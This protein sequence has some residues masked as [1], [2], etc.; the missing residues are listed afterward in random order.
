MKLKII[1]LTTMCFLV[2]CS[3]S[4]RYASEMRTV[5]Y[6]GCEYTY[7]P[8]SGSASL[9]HKGNCKG[10]RIREVSDINNLK[11][12]IDYQFQSHKIE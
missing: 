10:C 7:N 1:A 8:N 11:K 3:P 6:D 2:S 9:T 12:Y 5:D 4:S